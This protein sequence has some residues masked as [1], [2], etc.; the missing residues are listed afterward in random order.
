MLINKQ[1][2]KKYRPCTDRW[3]N[4]LKHYSEFSG[5]LIEFL[6]LDK[7]T[8]ADKWWVLDKKLKELPDE[9][10]RHF[11]FACTSRAV[12]DCKIKEVADYFNT[13]VLIYESG[14]LA[15]LNNDE[16]QASYQAANWAA[17]WASYQAADWA[18]EKKL[19]IDYLIELLERDFY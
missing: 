14:D 16:Y 9:L 6:K 18:A 3:N 5:N 8:V 19:Q 2:L 12:D 10:L 11:A 15:L 1:E 17:N 7:I 4:Y 13:V